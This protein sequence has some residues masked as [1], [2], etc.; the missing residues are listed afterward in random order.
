[1]LVPLNKEAAAML[2]SQTNPQ[3]MSSIHMQTLSFVSIE[4]HGS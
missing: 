3:G 2:L 1:M 4:K